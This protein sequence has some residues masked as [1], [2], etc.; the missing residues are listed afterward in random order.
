MYVPVVDAHVCTC[1]LV[2]HILLHVHR[3]VKVGTCTLYI[4]TCNYY[5]YN[6]LPSVSPSLTYF[7]SDGTLNPSGVRFGSAEIYAIG[8]STCYISNIYNMYLYYL[9][10][11]T[12]AK[13]RAGM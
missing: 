6:S 12:K 3:N 9:I 2:V 5:S 4:V 10:Y 11:H 13:P 1:V 7:L 8:N